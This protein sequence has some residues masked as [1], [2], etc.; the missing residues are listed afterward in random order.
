MTQAALIEA[1]RRKAERDAEALWEAARARAQARRDDAARAL[2]QRRI[3]IAAETAALAQE[4]ERAA[5]AEAQRE[6]RRIRTAAS[7][8]LA[9][10]LFRLACAALPQFRDE[11]YERLFA[12]L[13]EELPARPWQRVRV[14]P[15]DRQLAAARFAQAQVACD[16]A[17]VGGI[18]V[19]AE[20]GRIRISNTLLTRLQ[21]AWP[22]VLPRLIHQVFA[23]ASHEPPVA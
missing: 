11:H 17:I 5:I 7:T 9:A 10:R 1:L 23:E 15:A 20:D 16:E 14:H 6:A 3:Q 8:A 13:A 19:E 12:A 22:D 2:A 21:T 4:S 18:E